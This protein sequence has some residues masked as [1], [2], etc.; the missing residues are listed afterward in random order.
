M[1]F[2]S[3]V[4]TSDAGLVAGRIA[5]TGARF[6]ARRIDQ[7]A[8]GQPRVEPAFVL[9]RSRRRS[10][11]GGAGEVFAGQQPFEL[12]GQGGFGFRIEAGFVVLK[13]AVGATSSVA[14]T[15]STRN[16]PAASWSGSRAAGTWIASSPSIDFSLSSVISA[17]SR[18]TATRATFGL[19]LYFW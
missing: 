10:L 6:S 18:L 17:G 1:H 5:A 2:Q 3:E 13:F 16:L 9:F 14:G 11:L 4:K 8:V 19:S 12:S 15:P 7:D